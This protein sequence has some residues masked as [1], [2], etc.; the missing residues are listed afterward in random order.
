[1]LNLLMI[2]LASIVIM[3]ACNSFELGSRYLGRT[4]P[5]GIRGATINAIGSSLPELFTTFF[6]LFVYHDQRG[7]SAGIATCAGS[8]VFNAVVIPAMC[9]IT[10]L[11]F[12]VRTRTGIEKVDFITVQR[13]GI[14]RDAFFFVLSEVVLIIMLSAANVT[15]WMGGILVLLYL[16]YVGFLYREYK[17]GRL[18]VEDD[19]E[20]DDDEDLKEAKRPFLIKVLQLDFHGMLFQYSPMN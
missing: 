5:P 7:Y 8:A 13:K 2:V 10:V 4:F 11:Y 14:L 17:V 15:W 16:A 12:G 20:E 6:L 18:E 9:I 3:Y 19:E 1:M